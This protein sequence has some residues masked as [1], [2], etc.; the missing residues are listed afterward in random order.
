MTDIRVVPSDGQAVLTQCIDLVGSDDENDEE[1]DIDPTI[2][3]SDPGA[4]K[5]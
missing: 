4:G 3:Q 1:A 2:G 5:Q